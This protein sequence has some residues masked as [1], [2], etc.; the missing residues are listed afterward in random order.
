LDEWE[1]VDDARSEQRGYWEL[2]RAESEEEILEELGMTFIQPEKRNFG[3]LLVWNGQK[4]Q[5][6][7]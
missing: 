6:K 5:K 4:R 1:G 2:V 7:V 3:F